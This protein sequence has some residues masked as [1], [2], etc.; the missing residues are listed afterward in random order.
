MAEQNTLEEIVECIE[1]K[2]SFLIEAGA[3]SGKTRSLVDTLKYILETN[4]ESLSKNQQEIAC[5]TYTNVAKDEIIS[6]IDSNPLVLVCTIHEF[7]W[8]IIKNY[9]A[10]LKS[11]VVVLNGSTDEEENKRLQSVLAAKKIEYSQF[12]RNFEYGQISHDEVIKLASVLF[13][14]YPKIYRVVASKFPYILVDEYQDTEEKVVTLLVDKLLPANEG[15]L[16]VGFFGDSMQKIYNS[17]V[18][19]ITNP[20]LKPITKTENYRCSKEVIDLL[21]KIR[22]ELQQTPGTE[23]KQGSKSFFTSTSL[24][25]DN[26]TKVIDHLDKQGWDKSQTKIL[27]L[28]HKGIADKLAYS[29]ILKAYDTLSFGRDKLMRR[30]EP[31]SKL[32]DK[33]ER[34]AYF[35]E[36]KQYGEFLYLLGRVGLH[37]SK[38]DEKIAVKRLMDELS[39]LRKTSTIETVLTYVFSNKILT[40]PQDIKD[41]ESKIANEGDVSDSTEKKRKFYN[42]L[43]EVPYKEV[44]GVNNYVEEKTPFS[45]KH[46]VK[47]A[48]YENVVVVIDDSSWNQYKF[49]DVFS[50]NRSNAARYERTLN[51]FY[52]C[53]SR[54]KNN[55]SVVALSAFDANA[56]SKAEDWFGVENVYSIED[57]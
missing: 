18:G 3:G 6:R 9:Q 21:N 33:I 32:F 43:K 38:H 49:N 57:L 39:N 36:N 7:L 46:G 25:D 22:P 34:L 5:I 45:T 11:E 16:V 4:A 56:V 40:K 48:E 54:A 15:K 2:K 1:A 44:T 19:K 37:L 31:Y 24:E 23:V 42:L 30:E 28:T 29:S 52:V 20:A 27:M 35:Y 13:E 10:E 50:G 17:G 55:L 53:C 47:G 41:F 51:L 26:Y 8:H 14:K 12:G